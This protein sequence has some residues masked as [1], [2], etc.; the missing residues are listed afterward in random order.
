MSYL[1]DPDVGMVDPQNDTVDAQGS[2][3]T[4]VTVTTAEDIGVLT[5]EILFGEPRIRNEIVYLAGNTV[6]YGELADSLEAVL[7]PP[8]KRT[9]WSIPFLLD[10]LAKD[11][12]NMTKKYRA[13]F[14]QGRGVAWD[15][16]HTFNA[17]QAIPVTNACEWI[18]NNLSS[19]HESN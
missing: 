14:A 16:S 9:V 7:Q 17:R 10:D 13:V 8:F 12:E 19:H 18:G 4:A 1:F 15:K 11:P 5:A 3:D 2:L 6:T